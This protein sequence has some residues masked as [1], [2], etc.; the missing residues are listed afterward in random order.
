[1]NRNSGCPDPK[2]T[3]ITPMTIVVFVISHEATSFA[4]SGVKKWEMI[5]CHKESSDTEVFRLSTVPLQKKS[6]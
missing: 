2:F 1:M 3:E 5:F 6:E 4:K